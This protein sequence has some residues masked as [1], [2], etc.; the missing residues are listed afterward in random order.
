M[1][2]N[3]FKSVFITVLIIV[4]S[5]TSCLSQ[6]NIDTSI[7]NNNKYSNDN[8]QIIELPN[9]KYKT[10]DSGVVVIKVW[11]DKGGYIV[12]A[13]PD[14]IKTTALNSELIESS[15]KA[16]YKARFNSIDNDT[17]QIGNISF[18]FKLR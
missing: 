1:T 6:T 13:Q 7:V 9:P 11:I 16:A 12:N 4:C 18:I 15:L 17:I 10:Q 5:C 8:R 14:S 3:Y 2:K